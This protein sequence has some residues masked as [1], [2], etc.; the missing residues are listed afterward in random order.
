MVGGSA[1]PNFQSLQSALG[2]CT[3][4]CLSCL[5]NP[6]QN[7]HG[8][9]NATETVNKLLL[10]LFNDRLVAASVKKDGGLRY[11]ALGASRTAEWSDIG[12]IEAQATGKELPDPS[13]N[14]DL[15]VRADNTKMRVHVR[16]SARPG[17][18]SRVLRAIWTEPPSPE[19]RFRARMDF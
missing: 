3:C 15:P 5:L 17:A 2:F 7:I 14:L 18:W 12:V 1:Y 4:G 8:G 11:P 9:I 6:E 19:P 13:Y 16:P 10:N